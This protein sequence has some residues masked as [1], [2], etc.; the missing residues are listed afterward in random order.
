[1]IER[2]T[3]YVFF[4]DEDGL[5]RAKTVT[6]DV[7]KATLT[8]ALILCFN[9][10]PL[11]YS[12]VGNTIVVSNKQVPP[13]IKKAEELAPPPIE[14]KGRVTDAD[15]NPMEGVSVIVKGTLSGVTTDANGNYTISVPENSSKVLVFS[16]VGMKNQEISVKANATL[17]VVLKAAVRMPVKRVSTVS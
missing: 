8:E 9:N 16:F 11:G 5:Q 12:I 2:Q 7:K 1:M 15:G 10:Q 13:E 4:F 3:D 14:I 6:I 17:P